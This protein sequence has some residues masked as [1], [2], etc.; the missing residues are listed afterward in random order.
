MSDEITLSAQILVD[1]TNSQRET[2]TP[3]SLRFTQNN[4]GS[5]RAT[6]ALTTSDTTL[7]IIGLTTYGIG[8]FQNVS[9]STSVVIRVGADST[10]V[11]RPFLRLKPKQFAVLPFVSGT[12][13]RA[14][15]ESSSGKL[16]YGCWED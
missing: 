3:P 9:A 13:Y 11:I 5:F 16:L 15:C 7:G 10:G 14:Q 4:I 1:T 12:T 6:A 2:F 8:F